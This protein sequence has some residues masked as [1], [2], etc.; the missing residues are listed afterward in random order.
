VRDY[1]ARLGA[2][3]A[4]A[5]YREEL[6]ALRNQLEA[7][8]SRTAQEETDGSLPTLGALITRLKALKAAHT[9]DAAPPRA[10][11]RPP[12][13]VEEAITTRIRQREQGE[14]APQPEAARSP[15]VPATPEPLPGN[16]PERAARLARGGDTRPVPGTPPQRRSEPWQRP[17]QLR[18]F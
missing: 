4:H 18:L 17:Q 6:T 14:A 11:P 15:G 1:D 16:A 7:V 9:L 12:A 10:A 13:T 3:F 2:G 5:A 8:L